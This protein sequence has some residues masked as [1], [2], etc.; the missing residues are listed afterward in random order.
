MIETL[1]LGLGRLHLVIVTARLENNIHSRGTAGSGKSAVYEGF[2]WI[3]CAIM[4]LHRSTWQI[5]PD[6]TG[7]GQA[8]MMMDPSTVGYYLWINMAPEFTTCMLTDQY[9]SVYQLRLQVTESLKLQAPYGSG[10]IGTVAVSLIWA[11]RSRNLGKT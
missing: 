8:W 11:D 10:W 1:V 2:H 4:N 7:I 9:I 3:A 5:F 6:L